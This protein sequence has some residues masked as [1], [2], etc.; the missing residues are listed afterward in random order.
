M[1]NF[2][3]SIEPFER[4]ALLSGL[5]VM[6]VLLSLQLPGYVTLAL[7]AA[8][9]ILVARDVV[10]DAIKTLIK[11]YRMS[12]EFLMMVATFGAFAL[13]DYPEALAVMIFYK[14]G[15]CFEHYAQG[16]S[17]QEITSLIKLKPSIVRLIREDGSEE[18]VKPRKVKI[19]QKIRVLSGEAIALDGTLVG[20]GAEI[21]LS[22]LTGESQ[23]VSF[24][25]GQEIPSG[26]INLQSVIELIVT[27]DYKNSSIARLINLIEDAAMN[28]SRPEA[29]IT[30][31]AVYYTPIVVACAV[32]LAL[33]P[34]VVPDQSFADWLQR[35]LV[36]L[37]VSCPC[38]LVLSVPLSFFGGLGAISKT[39]VM[40][41]GS[42]YIEN[43]AKLK[44]LCF[45]KTGT[46]THGR[47]KVEEFLSR[48]PDALA[49]LCAL[50]AQSTHPIAV[51]IKRYG[52]EQGVRT[53]AAENVTESPG[54]G[55]EGD[56]EGHHVGAGRRQFVKR[57]GAKLDLEP[58]EAGTEIFLVK[59]GVLIAALSL[60]DE[61]K[62]ESYALFD[63]LKQ[64]HIKTAMI[65]GDKKEAALKVAD[66][67][68]LDDVRY[69][70]L[71]EDKLQA[72]TQIKQKYGVAGY[73]G[74]GINDAPVLAASDVGIAMG[75]FGSAAAVE[76]S[77][78]V[79][80][81]D[82]LMK[83]PQAIKLSRRTL[84]LAKQNMIFVIAAKLI[85]L[86]LGALGMASIWLAILGDVGL[87]ILA[88]LNAMRTLTWVKGQG[89]KI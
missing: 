61:V 35:G 84:A 20:E 45:D 37:V 14:I 54:F 48:D 21:N 34:L 23:S 11:R 42:I 59:D 33:V 13:G 9:Y 12:E 83:I 51:A 47:F 78:V 6:A 17:H 40:V 16:K 64:L 71:P 30:R 56:I 65:T 31:F 72:F 77:D 55:L 76:A 57:L 4:F 38:A 66:E 15:E 50:E 82:N 29:L 46:L 27:K 85:I 79:V 1:V 81:Q 60:F 3:R 39:G 52:E 2:F 43:M 70:Q 19:G 7:F 74:D 68:K 86:I 53:V 49:Y 25:K 67:L 73:A 75:Q 63:E 89:G 24:T 28:K 41:K 32:L 44:A 22:A 58:H 88:V 36:F 18:M 69:E 26:G 80:M 5:I 8:A 10:I 87:C 62:E